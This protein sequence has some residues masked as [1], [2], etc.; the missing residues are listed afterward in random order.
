[1]PNTPK[2]L[3][4]LVTEA[5]KR[6]A[7]RAKIVPASIIVLDERV[8]LKCSVPLCDNY[9]RHLLCPPNVMPM[10]QFRRTL[11]SF[12]HALLLQIESD[13][14]SLDKS[15]KH[16]DADLC[17]NLEKATGT[18]GFERKLT[19]LVEEMEALAFKKGFYLAAGLGGSECILCE[20][21]VGQGSEE[22]CRHPF[23][24]R[25]SM[26]ALGIDVIRTCESAGMPIRL[27]SDHKVRWTGIVLLD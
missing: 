26:Q 5:K 9:G 21:C 8:R 10:D 6:G 27:S 20:T 1:M 19:Q 18:R 4:E 11:K 24:A 25:P 7:S 13:Y 23:R 15:T 22:P 17:T 2:R 16:L 12:K 3:G 14:D